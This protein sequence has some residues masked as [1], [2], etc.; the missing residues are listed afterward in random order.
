MT[1][2]ELLNQT[3]HIADV[4]MRI[5]QKTIVDDIHSGDGCGLTP[6]QLQALRHIVRH[7]ASTV[8]SISEGLM[9]SQPAATML[10]DRMVKRGLVERKSSAGDRRQSLVVP[11]S[12]ADAIIRRV[13]EHRVGRLG[14]ILKV[15]NPDD[16]T[17]LVESLERFV[18]ASLQAE[19]DTSSACLRCGTDHKSDCIIN[20]ANLQMAGKDI[21]NI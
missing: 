13:E 8:G 7:G 16:R 5:M 11:T 14:A 2:S 21:E 10:V 4:F 6:V 20:K 15:M 19:S 3:E 12:D 17:L 18:T 9:I 1:E